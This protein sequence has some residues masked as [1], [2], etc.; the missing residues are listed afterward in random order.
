VLFF[1]DIGVVFAVIGAWFAILFT[2]RY[3]RGSFEFVVGVMRWSNPRRRLRLRA[4][5][6][7]L[8]AVPARAVTEPAL[9]RTENDLRSTLHRPSRA[10]A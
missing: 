2:G 9:A 8:P 10:R 6:R 7:P 5:D 3:P 1:L 4:P